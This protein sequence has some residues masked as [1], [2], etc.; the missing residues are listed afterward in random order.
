L[1]G[2]VLAELLELKETFGKSSIQHCFRSRCLVFD[3]H[4]SL[5]ISSG[6]TN[7]FGILF[8]CWFTQTFAHYSYPKELM[9]LT[10]HNII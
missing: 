4:A 3:L 9:S 6:L 1:T 2:K 7:I 10:V 5:I 8:L